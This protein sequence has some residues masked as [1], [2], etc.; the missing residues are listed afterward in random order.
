MKLLTLLSSLMVTSSALTAQLISTPTECRLHMG[1]N[2][3]SADKLDGCRMEYN[4]GLALSAESYWEAGHGFYIG[5]ETTFRYNS[6]D[7]V[8][9]GDMRLE[10]EG[11]VTKLYSSFNAKFAPSLRGGTLTPYIGAGVGP[12]IRW[13]IWEILPVRDDTYIYTFDTIR[14]SRS[15]WN[16]QY[17]VGCCYNGSEED[18]LGVE[19]RQCFD[20]D[21]GSSDL[22]LS[23]NI[24]K[25]F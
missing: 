18:T 23:F 4:I 17:F 13:S 9:V 1:L 22:A 2:R 12:Q 25:K 7:A 24:G 16:P 10:M 5:S 15:S 21:K 14:E 20:I 19:I 3:A 8:R 6:S 11:S